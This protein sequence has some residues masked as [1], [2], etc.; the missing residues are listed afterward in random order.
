MVDT[1]EQMPKLSDTEIVFEFR[2]ALVALYPIL[3]RLSCL[4][5]DTQ[6]YDDF[7][8]IAENLWR[9][10][11]ARSL[12]WK[13]ELPDVPKIPPYGFVEHK[14]ELDGYI[15][16]SSIRTK[17]VWR[18]L[19]FI[20]NRQFGDEIFNAVEGINENGEIDLC[21]LWSNLSFK[22]VSTEL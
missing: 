9:V 22:Y 14:D 18:F 15:E 19:Q 13:Y 12:M 20:G 7:D 1:D 2:N 6:P 21:G 5:D 4:E 3:T 8:S 16:V 10:M 17:K 11:V